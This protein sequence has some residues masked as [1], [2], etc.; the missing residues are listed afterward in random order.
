MTKLKLNTYAIIKE[1]VTSGIEWGLNRAHKHTDTPTRDHII[2]EI[3]THIMHELSEVINFDTDEF[4]ELG[5][6]FT[7]NIF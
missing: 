5:F 7:I 4:I 1:A 2:H 6:V 3:E